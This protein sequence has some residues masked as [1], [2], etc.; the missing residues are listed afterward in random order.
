MGRCGAASGENGRMGWDG[1]VRRQVHVLAK[2]GW[3]GA[4]SRRSVDVKAGAGSGPGSVLAGAQQ[5][6]ME[7]RDEEREAGPSRG[8]PSVP[9]QRRH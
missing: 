4:Q 7:E 1:W 9:P 6:E 2:R 5:E 8:C 3:V